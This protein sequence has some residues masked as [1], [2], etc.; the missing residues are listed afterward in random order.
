MVELRVDFRERIKCLHRN[1]GIPEN[2]T[3][4][5][6]DLQFEENDLIEI[7]RDIFDRTQ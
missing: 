4:G 5:G 6:L 1:L 2:Y 7:E 3:T